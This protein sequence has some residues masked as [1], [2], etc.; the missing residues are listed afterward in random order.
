MA[1]DEHLLDAT[2]AR[3]AALRI[4]RW[5]EPTLSLGYFQ[6]FA[7][8]ARLPDDV[9][10]LPAVRRLTGGGA[11]LHDREI[12]Y[13]LVLDRSHALGRSAPADLYRVAHE[14][15]RDALR[16]GNIETE[17]APD[18][19][20]LPTPRSGPFFCF[21]RPGRTDLLLDGTKL[22]GSAQRRAADRVLQHG[23]LILERRFASHPGA[24][25]GGPPE[26]AVDRWID[27]FVCLVSDALGFSPIESTWTAE[28]LADVAVRRARYADPTWTQRR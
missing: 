1:R 5:A 10:G 23:S 18:S 19:F 13:C 22:L 9:S 24:D 26:A 20:P 6:S 4:Y 27:R 21:E 15:W 28:M 8:V 14:C 3:G 16:E 2:P 17:L 25:L 7:E 12:T 11:I